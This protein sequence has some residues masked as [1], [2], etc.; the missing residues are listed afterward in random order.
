MK[1]I[2]LFIL[3]L[4]FLGF[5]ILFY[6]NQKITISVIVPVYN[7]EKYISKCLDSILSQKG[8]FEIIAVNDGSTDS[9]LK[10]LQE[11]AKNHKNIKIINQ[12][13]QGVSVARNTG[14]K[15][16]FSKYI[17][18][19]DSDD[20][21]EPNTFA[22]ALKIIKQDNPDIVLTSY[23]DVYDKEWVKN[24]R[25]E[26]DVKHVPQVRKF[27]SRALDK[28]S[29][30]TPFKTQDALSDLYYIGGGVRGRFFKRDF[31]SNTKITFAKGLDCYE[32]DVFIV[33]LFLHNPLV[34]II[35]KPLYNY[36]NRA[37]SISKSKNTLTCGRKSRETI[38]NSTAF[39]SSSRQEKMLIDDLF[40]SYL[41][42]SISNYT[43]HNL[44]LDAIIKEAS[45][46]YSEFNKYNI[47]ERKSLRNFLK[48][49]KILYG[50]IAS[51]LL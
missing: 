47:A 48:L 16:S 10:I 1:K 17:T 3:I 45:L 26:E 21:L 5:G 25:G 40:I 32:D 33:S 9:S 43:R 51:P 38:L 15:S 8:D 34:S 2:I 13:N 14:L 24:V 46:L 12:K 42:L 41:F 18:F 11:Y 6:Q 39:L 35:N 19:I 23:Y 28:L 37:D 31:L 4:A 29:L 44:P 22:E 30:F 36:L 49:H 27:P 50:N 7:A 20:W